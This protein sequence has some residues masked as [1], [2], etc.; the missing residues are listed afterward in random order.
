MGLKENKPTMQKFSDFVTNTSNALLKNFLSDTGEEEQQAKISYEMAAELAQAAHDNSVVVLQV[1]NKPMD[2][3][4]T[5]TGWIAN[6]SLNP[7]QL[8]IRLKGDEEQLKMIP[9]QN[10]L[11]ISILSTKSGHSA[12]TR[13]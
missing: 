9:L 6:K 1:E 12:I 5:Y 10:I 2:R 8:V 13:K 3:I 11:K 7:E 4:E